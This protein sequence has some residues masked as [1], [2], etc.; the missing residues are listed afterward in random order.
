MHAETFIQIK[1]LIENWDKIE[2]RWTHRVKVNFTNENLLFNFTLIFLVSSC[3]QN[4]QR[5][6]NNN[7]KI[8]QFYSHQ[9]KLP[10]FN[11]IIFKKQI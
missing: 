5:G 7:K 3:N 8:V 10:S 2:N 4:K 11:K 6:N 9:Q 1:F